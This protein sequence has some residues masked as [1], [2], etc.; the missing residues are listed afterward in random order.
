[1]NSNLSIFNYRFAAII[2]A[3]IVSVHGN[4]QTHPASESVHKVTVYNFLD[5]TNDSS[6]NLPIGDSTP[7]EVALT[8]NAIKGYSKKNFT[9]RAFRGRKEDLIYRPSWQ[10]K[11]CYI[12][13]SELQTTRIEPGSPDLVILVVNQFWLHT[14]HDQVSDE[15]WFLV[16]EE[17]ASKDNFV[18][19][20]S[21]AVK[22]YFQRGL[23]LTITAG[24]TLGPDYAKQVLSWYKKQTSTN[25]QAVTVKCSDG[26]TRILAEN[27]EKIF[28]AEPLTLAY[29]DCAN[30]EI[31]A[32]P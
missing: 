24:P 19:I 23:Q 26:P 17:G 11:D 14:S 5:I 3:M 2:V 28:D 15:D 10:D 16:L 20:R 21:D 7:V 1:M 27:D 32:L 29:A 8:N 12:Y 31:L 4:C 9:V 25:N 6:I 18:K 13:W 22:K 30:Q